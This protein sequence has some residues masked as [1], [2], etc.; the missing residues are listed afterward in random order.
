MIEA[1]AMKS[2][3]APVRKGN[4]RI[5]REAFNRFVMEGGMTH[6]AALAYYAVFSLGPLLLIATA[7][8]GWFFG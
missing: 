8:A 2:V 7:I 3:E 1:E 4:R 5:L 6:G